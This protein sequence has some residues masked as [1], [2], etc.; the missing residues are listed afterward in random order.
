MNG[1][2]EYGTVE[3]IIKTV[4]NR[5][6]NFSFNNTYTGIPIFRL[7]NNKRVYIG[8][9]EMARL[10]ASIKGMPIPVDEK[11]FFTMNHIDLA[12]FFKNKDYEFKDLNAYYYYVNAK[13]FSERAHEILKRIDI[14]DDYRNIDSEP[15][16]RKYNVTIDSTGVQGTDPHQKAYLIT[17]K[18]FDYEQPGN[19]PELASSAFDSHRI[20]VVIAS[21]QNGLINEVKNFDDY[22]GRTYRYQMPAISEVDWHM[23]ANN[24][25]MLTFM[26]GMP[27]GNYKFY[28]NYAVVSNGKTVEYINRDSIYVQPN[29][30]N[31]DGWNSFALATQASADGTYNENN[32]MAVRYKNMDNQLVYYDPRSKLF[33]EEDKKRKMEN[34]N[35]KVVC[36][37]LVDYD[38]DS[39]TLAKDDI[40]A[41]EGNDPNNL[42]LTKY[43]YYQ[44]GIAS[45]D[46]I[47]SRNN[48]YGKN[49]IN[50]TDMLIKGGMTDDGVLINND[51]R[52]AY[53]SALARF[54]AS[55]KKL[56]SEDRYQ[57][58]T[59]ISFVKPN[60]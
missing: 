5:D 47:V 41:I 31:N 32:V 29:Y 50:A 53:L 57:I 36:Y 38:K 59:Q 42:Q 20:D 46:S 54:R 52:I 21:I 11:N 45:Y 17:N 13:A 3:P 25:T 28:S 26:Q 33:N 24:S 6:N 49:S 27:I 37:R 30:Q 15:F 43:F 14:G 55:A 9:Y 8:T 4:G 34:V 35:Y 16:K 51:I 60:I 10:Y 7:E 58:N 40:G 23:I 39:I 22:L 48:L 56:S 12:G 18:I 44:P 1:G 19:D 2:S